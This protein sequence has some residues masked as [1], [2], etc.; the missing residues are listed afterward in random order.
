MHADPVS[1]PP[2]VLFNRIRSKVEALELGPDYELEWW[3]EYRD[4]QR[5]QAGIA[6]SLP[7][8]FIAMVLIV[9]G[10]FN[11]VKQLLVI[12]LTVPLAI[13]DVTWGLLITKQPFGFMALLGFMSL[14]G[15][16]IKN[17]IVLIDEIEIQ[18]RLGSSPFKAIVDSGVSHLRPIAM[19]ALTTDRAP[20]DPVAPGCLLYR[21]G[22]YHHRRSHGRHPTH[23]DRCAGAVCHLLPSA[24]RKD[25]GCKKCDMSFPERQ[26]AHDYR[27][28]SS[29]RCSSLWVFSTSSASSQPR[30][31]WLMPKRI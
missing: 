7:F 10:L 3:G 6:A 4:S 25:G 18:K 9:I 17:A 5:A 1:G 13:I 27:F 28:S 2:S 11:A 21:Y 29:L 8:F 16:L 23:H 22:G 20:Y 31:A 24:V 19:A 14:S 26:W 30:R 12:W 15:M